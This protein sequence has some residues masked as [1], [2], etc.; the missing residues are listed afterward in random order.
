V[1]RAV[2]PLLS[3]VVLSSLADGP[4]HAY[5]LKRRAGMSLGTFLRVSD[6]SLYPLLKQLER[7]GS[8]ESH[9]ERGE[10]NGPDRIVYRITEAGRRDVSERLA[11]P[12]AD[13]PE[14][15]VDFYIRVVCF[16]QISADVRLSL[17]TQRRLQVYGELAS[18]GEA[19]LRLAEA[20]THLEV[21]DLRERQLSV[22]REWLDQ[23]E[24]TL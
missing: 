12:L 7:S 3:L 6:G 22:E 4:T 19:R 18:L 9:V 14:A 21:I 8:I 15:A 23:L 16:P 2:T 24:R 20:G 11:Q 13:G 17:I 1:A 10:Q 5:E